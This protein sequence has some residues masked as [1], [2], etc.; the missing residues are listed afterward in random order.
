VKREYG[1]GVERKGDTL[2]LQRDKWRHVLSL[3]SVR[4]IRSVTGVFRAS[5]R[6]AFPG[7]LDCFQGERGS[8]SSNSVVQLHIGS[9]GMSNGFS[10]IFCCES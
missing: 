5:G 6:G 3:R 2:P 1:Q 4:N 9:V 8:L 10:K 7:C